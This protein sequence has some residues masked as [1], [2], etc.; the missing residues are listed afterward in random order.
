[1]TTTDFQFPHYRINQMSSLEKRLAVFI[2][3]PLRA[4]LAMI[5]SSK[6]SPTLSKNREYIASL[7][8]LHQK[9]LNTAAPQEKLAYYKA[10]ELLEK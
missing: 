8:Q 9:S 7:E 10:K 2:R 1:M 5:T 3:L 4:Q 6:S